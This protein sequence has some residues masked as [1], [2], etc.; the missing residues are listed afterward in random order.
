MHVLYEQAIYKE[1]AANA[2][3]LIQLHKE[4]TEKVASLQAD[5]SQSQAQNRALTE[6]ATGWESKWAA[7]QDVLSSQ[8]EGITEVRHGVHSMEGTAWRVH[9]MEGTAWRVLHGGYSMEGTAWRVLHESHCRC[10]AYLATSTLFLASVLWSTPSS[11]RDP[12]I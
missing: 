3:N 7:A 8:Q 4:T 12:A 1:S 5:L 11:A 6:A 9:S 10:I 2:Q